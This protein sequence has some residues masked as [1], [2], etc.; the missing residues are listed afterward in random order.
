MTYVRRPHTVAFLAV[1]LFVGC[2]QTSSEYV[3]AELRV[4]SRKVAELENMVHQREA[5]IETLR[6]TVTTFQAGHVKPAEAPETVYRDTALSRITLTLATGGKDA[7]LD[8]KDDGVVVGVAPR[9][10]DGDVFKCPGSCRLQ[11]FETSPAGVRKQ[12]GEWS[13]SPEQLRTLWRASLLGQGYHLTSSWQTPP[14]E[15]KLRAVVT[16]IT[17]DGRQF[18]AE[19][20]FDVSIQPKSPPRLPGARIDAEPPPVISPVPLNAPMSDL[21]KPRGLG[22]L[23]K[24]EPIA[25]PPSRSLPPPPAINVAAKPPAQSTTDESKKPTKSPTTASLGPDQSHPPL[26]DRERYSASAPTASP[27]DMADAEDVIILPP[28]THKPAIEMKAADKPAS[29]KL[30]TTPT[31]VASKAKQAERIELLDEPAPP[32]SAKNLPMSILLP[33]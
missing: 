12:I 14:K 9:D 24:I 10:Y 7:D 4:Q 26:V 2:R 23:S 6:N 29:P 30:E 13:V 3:E 27:G 20:D 5:E 8:G 22:A 15:Q 11:L 33:N 1:C 19:K 16:F 17:V 18:E 31:P 32:K 21:P 28:A 25:A